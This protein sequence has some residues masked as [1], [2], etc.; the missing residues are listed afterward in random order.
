MVLATGFHAPQEQ[1]QGV[2]GLHQ[3]GE[4]EGDLDPC[5]RCRP[6]AHL[7]LART[8]GEAEESLSFSRFPLLDEHPDGRE[9][10][11]GELT[12]A[13]HVVPVDVDEHD[14]A[15]EASRLEV[16]ADEQGGGIAACW[17]RSGKAQPLD[18]R[19]VIDRTADDR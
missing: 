3:L 16:P 14:G 2:V 19:L 17:Q 12:R 1:R 15:L 4:L 8:E 13:G 18:R 10:R 9:R 7:L 5:R 11:E 6:I